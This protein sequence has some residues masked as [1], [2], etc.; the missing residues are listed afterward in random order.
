MDIL[1]KIAASK[2][3]ASPSKDFPSKE[4]DPNQPLVAIMPEQVGFDRPARTRR[5]SGFCC[6]F[7][8]DA[9]DFSGFELMDLTSQRR[10]RMSRYAD[11][12]SSSGRV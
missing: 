9:A 6:Y 4:A 10:W 2:N 12:G 8:R 11:F 1:L 7:G 5:I 3:K